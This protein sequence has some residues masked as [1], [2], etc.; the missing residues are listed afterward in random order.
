MMS[1]L[2]LALAA[3]TTMAGDLSLYSYLEGEGITTGLEA[4]GQE[5][6]VNGKEL[7][8]LSGSLHYFRSAKSN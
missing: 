2:V 6:R 7:K 5:F 8:I 4:N 1:L 3:A